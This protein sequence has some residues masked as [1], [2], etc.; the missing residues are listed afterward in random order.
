[1]YKYI[2]L[3]QMSPREYDE[4]GL[5]DGFMVNGS[6]TLQS[7]AQVYGLRPPTP[8]THMTVGEY[9]SR[10]RCGQPR[11]GDKAEWERVALVI[12]EM[13]DGAINKVRLTI[14]SLRERRGWLE[15]R[16]MNNGAH[17][18]PRRP[19]DRRMAGRA[20]S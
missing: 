1:M 10:V 16:G 19:T 9:L 15:R 2:G 13:Q 3:L 20:D 12:Q 8:E 5:S 18:R 17:G 11:V 4:A 14:L 6:A 7:L